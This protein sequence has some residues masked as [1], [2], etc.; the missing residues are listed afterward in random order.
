[1]VAAYPRRPETSNLLEVKRR[2]T[3]VLFET[4]VGPVRKLL[5]VL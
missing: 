4:L 3:L 1:M 5:D 2:V